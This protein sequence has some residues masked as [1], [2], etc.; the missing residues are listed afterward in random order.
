MAPF[1]AL[2]YRPVQVLRHLA[3]QR[4]IGFKDGAQRLNKAPS[5]LL[6][7]RATGVPQLVYCRMLY[8]SRLAA[9]LTAFP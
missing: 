4:Q 3:S 6:M 1:Q 9:H 5:K 7:L 8:K 2:G